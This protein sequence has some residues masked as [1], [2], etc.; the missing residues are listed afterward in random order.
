MQFRLRGWISSGGVLLQPELPWLLHRRLQPDGLS[1]EHRFELLQLLAG[2]S[3]SVSPCELQLQFGL[4]YLAIERHIKQS[5]IL[6]ALTRCVVGNPMLEGAEV[7]EA[8]NALPAA[9]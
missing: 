9:T 1:A 3:S 4:P 8:G 7:E 5:D 2:L 6:Y